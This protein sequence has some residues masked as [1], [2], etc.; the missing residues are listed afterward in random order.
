MDVEEM[1]KVSMDLSSSLEKSNDGGEVEGNGDMEPWFGARVFDFQLYFLDD[2]VFWVYHMSN[3]FMR[4]R[5][6][7]HYLYVGKFNLKQ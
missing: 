5:R 7:M 6:H 3:I 1:E 4:E 2:I